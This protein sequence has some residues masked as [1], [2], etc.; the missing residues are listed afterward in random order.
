[1][2]SSCQEHKKV[3]SDILKIVQK[4]Q[5]ENLEK[6]TNDSKRS[7]SETEFLNLVDLTEDEVIEYIKKENNLNCF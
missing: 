6:I 3:I 7:R 2:N 5:K 1:M 4:F